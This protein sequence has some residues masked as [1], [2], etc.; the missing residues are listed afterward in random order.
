MKTA[1][2]YLRS[3]LLWAL[4]LLHFGGFAIVLLILRMLFDHRKLDRLVKVY[5]RNIQLCSGMRVRYVHAAGFDPRRTSLF[6]CNHVNM[7][8][9]FVVYDGIP[10][11]ARGLELESHFEIPFYGWLMRRFGNV[12]IPDERSPAALKKTFRLTEQALQSGTSL[13]MFP[14]G[15]RT[16][17]GRVDRFE[18]GAFLLAQKFKVPLVPISIVGSFQHNTK[19]SWLLR[20]ARITVHIHD[21]IE[22]SGLTRT[23]LPALRERVWEIVARPVHEHLEQIRAEC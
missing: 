23:D 8:D 4:S 9:P 13:V 15:H 18:D 22:T 19:D 20:P 12:P 10:Q 21:T 3:T 2:V 14:E 1:Y 16:R 7:F 17:N 5:S 11:F 6:V